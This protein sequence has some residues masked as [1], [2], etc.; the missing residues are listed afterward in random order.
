MAVGCV[1]CG[2]RMREQISIKPYSRQMPA[3]PAGGVP[4]TGRLRTLTAAE[5]KNARNP[6]TVSAEVLDDGRIYYGYYCL[7]CH[8]ATGD[9]N[10]PVGQ[11][12]VP[13]PTD[14]SSEAVRRLS[15]GQLYDRMLHGVGH[16]PVMSETVVPGHRW[17]I[18]AYVRTFS[19][20]RR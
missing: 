20:R 18:V 9:G 19:A 17:Q 12:Y 2:P 14:L 11:S 4:T 16:D 13:E 10:G 15:D 3:M 7:M 6:L 8:G 1:S 5:A